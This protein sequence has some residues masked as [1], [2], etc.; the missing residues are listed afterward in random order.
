MFDFVALLR[1]SA[2]ENASSRKGG[3]RVERLA[4]RSPDDGPSPGKAAQENTEQTKKTEPPKTQP[5]KPEPPKQEPPKPEPPKPEPKPIQTEALEQ[6]KP[7]EKKPEPVKQE[8][9]KPD[10]KNLIRKSRNP[11]KSRIIGFD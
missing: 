4:C 7:E 2:C 9:K 10:V 3:S 6:K 8:Q 1:R 5:P 11:N